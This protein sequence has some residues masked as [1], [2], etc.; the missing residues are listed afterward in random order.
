MAE[1]LRLAV[2][3]VGHLGRHHA[4]IASTLEGAELVA[5]VDTNAER[6]AAAASAT[7][8][9]ARADYRDIIDTVDAVTIAVPMMSASGI[10]LRASIVS[11]AT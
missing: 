5:V 10:V 2:I 3:G 11:P 4:R 7:G 6:A 9:P 1:R 8:A